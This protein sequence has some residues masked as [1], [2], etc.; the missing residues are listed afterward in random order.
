MKMG[1]LACIHRVRGRV[2][3]YL[4]VQHH[5]RKFKALRVLKNYPQILRYG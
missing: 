3:I 5:I 4:H 2:L 1:D